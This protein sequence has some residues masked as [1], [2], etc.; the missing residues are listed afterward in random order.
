LTEPLTV[1]ATR[2][3]CPLCESTDKVTDFMNG[4][5]ICIKCG[6]VLNDVVLSR[7]EESFTSS[8]TESYSTDTRRHGSGILNSIYDKGLSTIITGDRDAYGA[9]ISRETMSDMRRFQKHDNRSKVNESTSR[10][11]SIAMAELDR[12]SSALSLP[13]SVKEEAAHIYRK[14]LKRD[15]IRGRSI[16]SFVAA[17][18]YAAC[19][20]LNIPRPLRTVVFE[21]KRDHQEVSMTYRLIVNELGLRPPL[22]D[23]AKY[24][25]KLASKLSVNRK[26]E[27]L[28]VS[29]IQK[30]QEGQELMGKDPRGVSAAALYLAC[31]LENEKIVQRHIAKAAGTTEVTLRNRYRGLKHALNIGG[32]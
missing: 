29:L 8:R 22:D 2:D 20:M 24:I 23:P 31:E 9:P 27:R 28:A 12:L 6:C 10:N 1:E 4:E 3:K 21:S 19:R 16:D 15:M 18:L 11:L 17:S 25:P 5:E 14:T 30:A 26:T 13:Q 7:R 32:K